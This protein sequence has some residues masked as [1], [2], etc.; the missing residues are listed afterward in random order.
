MI[1][2][3]LEEQNENVRRLFTITCKSCGNPARL[4]FNAGHVHPHGADLGTLVI[5]CS[6]CKAGIEVESL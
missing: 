4:C 5:E 2:R 6:G 1:E 3:K